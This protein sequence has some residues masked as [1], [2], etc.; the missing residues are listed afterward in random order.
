MLAKC[1][2]FLFLLLSQSTLW[3]SDFK[4]A[5]RL[6]QEGQFK[7]ASVIYQGAVTK[8]FKNAS[9]LFNLGNSFYKNGEKGKAMAAY[10]KAQTLAPRDPDIRAN[11]NFLQKQFLDKFEQTG[12]F[13]DEF[14]LSDYLS[15]KETFMLF[16]SSLVL[17][18]LTFALMVWIV[19]P[20]KVVGLVAS[21]FLF[22]AF[23]FGTI[24]SS[25]EFSEGNWGAVTVT[26][27][28]VFAGPSDQNS[29]SVFKLHEGAPVKLIEE[30]GEW[31]AIELLDL[32]R[33]WVKKSQ[34]LF[35]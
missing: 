2:L 28:E 26:E 8:E 12:S 18:M 32:K 34:T 1:S 15:L 30:Q 5:A 9:T 14:I 10:L 13:W 23:V 4:E 11:L 35:L 3:A 22:M 25:R 27:V 7:E 21:I 17:S 16:V 31:V 29:V 33:G 19:K 24:Y 20:S 6:Y